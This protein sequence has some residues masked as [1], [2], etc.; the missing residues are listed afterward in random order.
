[1]IHHKYKSILKDYY[2]NSNKIGEIEKMD[3]LPEK[4]S[5]P[6]LNHEETENYLNIH[7]TNKEIKSLWTDGEFYKHLKN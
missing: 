4:Y 2:K 7:M 1:M 3:Q 6:K 5:L